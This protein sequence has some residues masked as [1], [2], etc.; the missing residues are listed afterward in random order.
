MFYEK[1]AEAKQEKREGLSGLQMGGVGLVGTAGAAGLHYSKDPKFVQNFIRR[2]KHDKTKLDLLRN[3]RRDLA[4]SKSHL[5]ELKKEWQ[6]MAPGTELGAEFISLTDDGKLKSRH[7][8]K[9]HQ[10]LI[11]GMDDAIKERAAEIRGGYAPQI[12]AAEEAAGAV[13][14]RRMRGVR[15]AKPILGA[16]AAGYGAKKL[17]DRH[18]RRKQEKRAEAKRA[19]RRRGLGEDHSMYTRARRNADRANIVAGALL[20]GAL[21]HDFSGGP[22]TTLASKLV[23]DDLTLTP[24]GGFRDP[25]FTLSGR[26]SHEALNELSDKYSRRIRAARVGA[27]VTAGLIGAG[28]MKR[29]ADRREREYQARRQDRHDRYARR[30]E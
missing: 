3:Q 4:Q 26:M 11:D 9:V 20:P 2:N 29:R 13:K 5:Q 10:E 6:K 14:S 17:F 27:G 28:L 23:P 30:E 25:R 16:L 8:P 1:L 21:V 7:T 22:I 15:Y 19:K 18:N 12:R 24:G